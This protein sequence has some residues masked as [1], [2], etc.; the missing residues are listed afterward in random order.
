MAVLRSSLASRGYGDDTVAEGVFFLRLIFF[1]LFFLIFFFFLL[2]LQGAGVS[3]GAGA[4]E[5]CNK[6]V[7][8]EGSR[9]GDG[10]GGSALISQI[11]QF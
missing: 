2:L 3:S 4:R 10:G 1:F 5:G 11:A 9:K 8:E 7:W 6:Y